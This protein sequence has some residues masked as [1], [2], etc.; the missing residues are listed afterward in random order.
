VACGLAGLCG[1]PEA[2]AQDPLLLQRLERLEQQNQELRQEIGQRVSSVN[3]EQGPRYRA[4]E[5]RLLLGVPWPCSI[6]S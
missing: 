1:L 5:G 6:A 2:R 4:G 3:L